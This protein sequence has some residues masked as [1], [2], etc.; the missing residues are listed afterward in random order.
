MSI[1]HCVKKD[2]I[3][4]D[5]A[6]NSS[7]DGARSLDMSETR[8]AEHGNL[9]PSH[10]DLSGRASQT[11]PFVTVVTGSNRATVLRRVVAVSSHS[12]AAIEVCPA[13]RLRTSFPGVGSRGR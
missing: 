3:G 1:R 11:D 5:V 8:A 7:R 4:Q 10:V 2:S 13:T 12:D 6:G 9:C